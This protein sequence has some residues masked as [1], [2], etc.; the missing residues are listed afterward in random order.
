MDYC[1]SLAARLPKNKENALKFRCGRLDILG[2]WLELLHRWAFSRN[3]DFNF[4][5]L[6]YWHDCL[7]YC[8]CIHIFIS[9]V[10]Q[11][12][13]HRSINVLKRHHALKKQ[14][15]FFCQFIWFLRSI[16]EVGKPNIS[17]ICNS[18]FSLPNQ[19]YMVSNAHSSPKKPTCRPIFFL[20]IWLFVEYILFS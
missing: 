8:S 9:F 10:H 12:L 4:N 16:N 2:R 11:Q 15:S 17:N 5:D 7:L 3:T 19:I 1:S 6:V 20:F 18:H 14:R 13:S